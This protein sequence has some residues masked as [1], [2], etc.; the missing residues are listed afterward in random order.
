MGSCSKQQPDVSMD[1]LDEDGFGCSLEKGTNENCNGKYLVVRLKISLDLGTYL[2]L[3][4][5]LFLGTQCEKRADDSIGITTKQCVWVLHSP[6]SS[7]LLEAIGLN[8]QML[9]SWGFQIKSRK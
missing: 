2:K 5:Y 7:A 6:Y 4:T 9:P 8:S 3:S 1:C